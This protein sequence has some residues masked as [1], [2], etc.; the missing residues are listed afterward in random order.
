[1]VWPSETGQWHGCVL[2][3]KQCDGRVKQNK[4]MF[5]SGLVLSGLFRVALVM[6]C[7]VSAANCIITHW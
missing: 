1:M 6:Q 3:M 7:T 4:E 5:C 2:V